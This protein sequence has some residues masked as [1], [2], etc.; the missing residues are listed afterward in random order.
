M[1]AS[2]LPGRSVAMPQTVLMECLKPVR[3]QFLTATVGPT[4]RC[5]MLSSRII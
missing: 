1:P 4:A 5:Q 2:T 3:I